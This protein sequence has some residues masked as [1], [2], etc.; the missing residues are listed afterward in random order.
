MPEKV[1]EKKKKKRNLKAKVS[2]GTETECQMEVTAML[3]KF[4]RGLPH[5]VDE[6]VIM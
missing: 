2:E 6:L 4:V 5:I 3:K 1:F